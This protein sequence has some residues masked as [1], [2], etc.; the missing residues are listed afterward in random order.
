MDAIVEENTPKRAV[1]RTAFNKPVALAQCS[2]AP[3]EF[4]RVRITG[5]AVSS[6]KGE[7]A[8]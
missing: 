6:F 5:V 8:L 2:R 1:V 4:T 7:E 3:G